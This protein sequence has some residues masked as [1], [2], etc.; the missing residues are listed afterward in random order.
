[1]C[2]FLS[3]IVLR[4]G[5]VLCEPSLTNHE[6]ILDYFGIP[7]T[8]G[9]LISFVRVEYSVCAEEWWDLAN[10]KLRVD[11]KFYPDWWTEEVKERVTRDMRRRIEACIIRDK[12]AVLP[13]GVYYLAPGAE[14]TRAANCM[15]MGAKN[16]KISMAQNV[17][18]GK[19]AD[20]R[21]DYVGHNTYVEEMKNCIVGEMHPA[22]VIGRIEGKTVI[23]YFMGQCY[24]VDK[25]A[26]IK[27]VGMV[28]CGYDS[29]T[30]NITNF[31]GTI[32]N[33]KNNLQIR[34]LLETARIGRVTK[35]AKIKVLHYS[36]TP[37][38]RR[39]MKRQEFTGDMELRK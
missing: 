17:W 14:V 20:S 32:L 30:V 12:R 10:W 15:I 26:I 34:A 39:M 33:V 13:M 4:D 8:E 29:H 11:E 7:Q 31:K 22:S 1:M 25:D 9:S 35:P 23:S 6:D 16:A 2:N 5:T 28:R 3:A 27:H 24:F 18:M 21:L 19:V 38:I 36:N 37:K